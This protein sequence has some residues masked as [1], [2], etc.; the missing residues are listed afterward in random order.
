MDMHSEINFSP[1]TKTQSEQVCSG[2]LITTL[3]NH[4]PYNWD[5]KNPSVWPQLYHLCFYTF[6]CLH[7]TLPEETVT[8]IIKTIIDST[9]SN[10]HYSSALHAY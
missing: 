10:I 6:M 2:R 7:K 9:K 5:E 1:S 4:Q 8:P 3:I